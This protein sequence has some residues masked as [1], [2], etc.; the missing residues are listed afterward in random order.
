MNFRVFAELSGGDAPARP[1][2]IKIKIEKRISGIFRTIADA[3]EEER[4]NTTK[5]KTKKAL[6]RD[7]S[8]SNFRRYIKFF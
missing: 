1:F 3:R 6:F 2:F 5:K 8:R 4:R 7:L